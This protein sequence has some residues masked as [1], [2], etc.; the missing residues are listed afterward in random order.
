MKRNP[1]QH[2]RGS[3]LLVALLTITIMTLICATSLYVGLQNTNAGI[4]TSAWQQALS[5][6][7]NGM[8][9][10]INALHLNAQ[11]TSAAWSNRYANAASSLPNTQPSGGTACPSA[12]PAPTANQYY[13]LPLTAIAMQGERSNNVSGW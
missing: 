12:T 11:G 5:G 3:V 9:Q 13:Y 1:N 8:T 7:E 4:Q 10:A 2:Q 6:A